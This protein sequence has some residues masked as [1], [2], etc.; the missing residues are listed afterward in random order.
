MEENKPVE[1]PVTEV[2]TTP[3]VE[4]QP[5]PIPV[6]PVEPVAPVVEPQ[7]IETPVS[8]APEAPVAPVTE[9]Q[10]VETPTPVVE[11]QPVEVPKKKS[12]VLPLIL[13]IVALILIGFGVTYKSK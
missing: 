11:V 8:V 7:P 9:P 12:I 1:V 13:I 3:V 4:P 2:P 10:P 6:A 5:A